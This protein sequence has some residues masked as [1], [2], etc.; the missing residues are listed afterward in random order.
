[1]RPCPK[2]KTIR[3]TGRAYTL[4]R[5]EVYKRDGRCCVDCHKFLQFEEAHL[6]HIIS[7]GAGGSDTPEN[8]Q[9]KCADCHIKEHGPRWGPSGER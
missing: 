8:T 6:C 2:N 3:L 4:L 9:I 5:M 1:M 7:K